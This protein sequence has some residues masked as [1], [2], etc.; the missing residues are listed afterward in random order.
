LLMVEDNAGCSE[1]SLELVSARGD[2][3]AH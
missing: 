2:I 1:R 3:V